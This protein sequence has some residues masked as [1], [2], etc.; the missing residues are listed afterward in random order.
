VTLSQ[1]IFWLDFDFDLS[2]IISCKC[3]ADAFDTQLNHELVCLKL[4]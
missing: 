4:N 2:Q 3:H 1:I